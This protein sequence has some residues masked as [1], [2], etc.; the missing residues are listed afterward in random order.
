MVHAV[1]TWQGS[2]GEISEELAAGRDVYAT[3]AAN[4]VALT[5]G[6]VVPCRQDWRDYADDT[7][8]IRFC[9]IDAE[10]S[11][12][13]VH[14]QI[15]WAWPLISPGGIL[16][17]DDVHHGPVHDA[18]YDRLEPATD[19]DGEIMR[20]GPLWFVRKARSATIAKLYHQACTTPSDIYEHLPLF[21][22]LCVSL[23]A[24]TV[25]E[26]GTRGGVS[27]I[28]WLYGLEETDGHLW[29]VDLDP[30]PTL[31]SHRWTFMQGDDLDPAIA[32]RLP[33]E[34]DVLFIDTSHAYDHTLA[35]LHVYGPR[36]RPGGRIVLHD[37]EIRQP[38]GLS[39]QP[40]Y[41]VRKAMLEYCAD[42]G[43]EYRNLRNNN[44]LGLVE[45]PE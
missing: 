6:N 18:V 23:E 2:K 25:V 17:G 14:D 12:R 42:E 10:H 9:F 44:G 41:P 29:S 43:Y 32:A 3:F 40:P 26:L 7:T 45:I 19:R 15:A 11:Y 37:T 33:R 27:T 1:D 20:V 5:A 16:C 8:P 21:V 39:R 24:K 38:F 31:A 30:A 22:D 4:V 13:E 34:I 36:V 35:E 28:A